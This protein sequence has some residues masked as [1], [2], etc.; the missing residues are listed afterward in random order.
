MY[1]D[2]SV[3]NIE[4]YKV[5]KKTAKRVLS[6]TKD[7]VYEDLYRSFST[8]EGEKAIYRMANV[9]E[10]KTGDFNRAKCIK[11][12]MGHLLVN[13]DEI[14]HRWRSILTNYSMWRMGTQ[15]FSWMAHLMTPIITLCIGSKNPRLEKH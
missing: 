5:A 2:K 11:D 14:R 7:R 4:E 8:K 9:R 15:P 1:H 12:E 6:V 10:R 3:D 13:K